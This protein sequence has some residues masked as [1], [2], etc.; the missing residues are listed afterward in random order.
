MRQT[1][2]YIRLGRTEEILMMMRNGDDGRE[3]LVVVRNG[4]R[5]DLALWGR[6]YESFNRLGERVEWRIRDG[7]PIALIVRMHAQNARKQSLIVARLEPGP[8]CVVKV[9]DASRMKNAN[10]VARAAADTA[11]ACLWA[12]KSSGR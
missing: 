2:F 12:E 7:K 6:V 3:N 11:A 10:V 1:A 9:I 4:Q 5:E 8:A